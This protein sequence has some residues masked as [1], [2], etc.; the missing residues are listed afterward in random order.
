MKQLQFIYLF[1]SFSHSIFILFHF[2]NKLQILLFSSQFSCLKL[3]A[4]I[5]AINSCSLS[6]CRRTAVCRRWVRR[7]AWSWRERCAAW[8]RAQHKRRVW[9]WV[10]IHK[11]KKTKWKSE[12]KV[13]LFFVFVFYA[14]LLCGRLK[15]IALRW[16]SVSYKIQKLFHIWNNCE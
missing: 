6:H 8:R 2:S 5:K 13:Y 10:A 7:D 14:I 1:V 4:M 12:N 3:L 16:S 11:V 15:I 9:L